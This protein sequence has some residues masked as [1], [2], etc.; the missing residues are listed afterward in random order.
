VS[1]GSILCTTFLNFAKM[2]KNDSVRL[3]FGSGYFFN[4]LKFSTMATYTYIL[5]DA[6]LE[7]PE[8]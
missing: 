5:C 8:Y 4:L 3:R 2:F 1:S 7:N 6:I